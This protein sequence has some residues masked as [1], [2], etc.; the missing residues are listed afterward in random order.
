MP[1]DHR[2]KLIQ[3]FIIQASHDLADWRSGDRREAILHAGDVAG[4]AFFDIEERD[5]MGSPRPPLR[6]PAAAGFRVAPE[7]HTDAV[8]VLVGEDPLIYVRALDEDGGKFEVRAVA[9]CRIC[10]IPVPLSPAAEN[11]AEFQMALVAGSPVD[12]ECV[13][14]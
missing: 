6:S 4:N 12:H 14:M 9:P 10:D 13:R 1:Q 8:V 2:T 5:M 7:W 11:E 3:D